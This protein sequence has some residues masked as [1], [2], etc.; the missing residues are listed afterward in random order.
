[1]EHVSIYRDVSS[2][3][4]PDEVLSAARVAAELDRQYPGYRWQISLRNGIA[5]IRN[6]ALDPDYGYIINLA[7]ENAPLEKAATRAAGEILERTGLRRNGF[8]A[9]AYAEAAG[10]AQ[11]R[12]AAADDGGL[13]QHHGLGHPAAGPLQACALGCDAGGPGQVV[14]TLEVDATDADASGY[15]PVWQSGT[16]I[17][18]VTSGGYG[19]SVGKSLAMALLEPDYMALGTEL[20]VHIVGV[21]RT[22]RVIP[23][24][25][26][27]PEGAC[28][29]K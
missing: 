28:M 19:H 6:A 1:M 13:G 20:S 16:R 18:F 12:A 17:G 10:Q 4:T 23:A 26:H 15:E 27:D 9:T 14:V 24:S 11:G 5:I 2:Q 3:P 8:D 21:E 22:A 7:R 25:P 29:R